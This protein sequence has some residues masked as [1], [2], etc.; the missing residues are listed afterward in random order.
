MYGYPW[1]KYVMYI[2]IGKTQVKQTMLSGTGRAPPG[3]GTAL[4]FSRISKIL[5]N[6]HEQL[7]I[8]S[9]KTSSNSVQSKV[10]PLYITNF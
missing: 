5:K 1:D 3:K 2:V 10:S 7:Q 9:F 8:Q 4:F 6:L